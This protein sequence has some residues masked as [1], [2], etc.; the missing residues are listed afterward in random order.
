MATKILRLPQVKAHTGL[1]RS[2][3][4]IQI[5][6]GEFPQQIKLGDRAVGWREAD[7]ENWVDGQRNWPAEGDYK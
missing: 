4:Y 2:S 6:R 3:I 7:I 5:S 1:S